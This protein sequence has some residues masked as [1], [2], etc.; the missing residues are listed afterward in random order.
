MTVAHNWLNVD[1]NREPT[2]IERALDAAERVTL[3]YESGGANLAVPAIEY[4]RLRLNEA[5]PKGG[6][7]ASNPS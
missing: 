4:L 6:T 2:P 5:R 7:H 1:V 3:A